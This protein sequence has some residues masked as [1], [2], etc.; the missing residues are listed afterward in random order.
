MTRV[1]AYRGRRITKRRIPND[2][3]E[4]RAGARAGSEEEGRVECVAP[5]KCDTVCTPQHG[6]EFRRAPTVPPQREAVRAGQ[7][8]GSQRVRACGTREL[9]HVF[10][11]LEVE[12]KSI[13]A[14]PRSLCH[15][16]AV[17][18]AGT[19][20]QNLHIPARTTTQHIALT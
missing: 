7:R 18:S 4:G 14:A 10:T 1:E 17:E 9:Q 15:A 20:T 6:N 11:S 12:N 2:A 16:V 19:R 5:G 3:E 8:A 13:I